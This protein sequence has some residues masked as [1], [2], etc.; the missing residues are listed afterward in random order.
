[1]SVPS[2]HDRHG[3][4]TIIYRHEEANQL[5]RPHLR[6]SHDCQLHFASTTTTTTII[7]IIIAVVVT[8]KVCFFITS[9]DTTPPYT[10]SP[11][12]HHIISDHNDDHPDEDIAIAV[13]SEV[14]ASL[15]MF[16]WSNLCRLS[17]AK[18]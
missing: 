9:H 5:D 11:E 7:I 14:E 15:W 2:A 3:M 6:P 16:S 17:I 1:M 12:R 10:R 8:T 13:G 18:G 4:L